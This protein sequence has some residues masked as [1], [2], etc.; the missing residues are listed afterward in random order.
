[1]EKNSIRSFIGDTIPNINGIVL[2]DK[3]GN[4]KLLKV[5]KQVGQSYS[6]KEIDYIVNYLYSIISDSNSNGN[7]NIDMSNI[8]TL[9]G[10]N[11][12]ISVNRFTLGA[13]SDVEATEDN[14][15]ITLG[16]VNEILK[17]YTPGSSS[18]G[19]AFY[20][21]KEPV[22]NSI[23][24][25]SAGTTFDKTPIQDIISMLLYPY[26]TPSIT[27][28]TSNIKQNYKLGEST[29]GNITLT[30]NT[31]NQKNIK[32]NSIRFLFNNIELPKENFNKQGSKAFT[33]NPVKLNTQ[34]SINIVMEMQDIKNKKMSRNITLTWYNGIYYG[35]STKESITAEDAVKLTTL[36]ANSLGRDY[37]YPGGGYKY[38]VFPS[39]WG[40][41]KQF[42]DPATNFD[43]PMD[44][45]DNITITNNNGVTQTYKV[46]KSTN[47]L[48]GDITI[49]V[50]A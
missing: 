5:P 12:F 47:V 19:D 32:E 16:Q 2:I 36:D 31:S 46:Y 49:R 29:P 8:A 17:N 44:K 40:D 50:K 33:I 15:L 43:I 37:R 3:R 45:K 10:E 7:V 18:G 28:F 20:T 42:V 21:N 41:P 4:R 23:G 48:N 9:D 24:G 26:Q 30:W 6:Q 38:L 39:T 14:D 1:M 13:K 25:I 22:P 34:G 27:Q 35:N 11:L